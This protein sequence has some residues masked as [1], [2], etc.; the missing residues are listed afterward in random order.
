MSTLKEVIENV[1]KE[2]VPSLEEVR[3]IN[4][5]AKKMKDTIFNIFKDI[6]EEEDVFIGG[7]VSRGTYL[8]NEFDIDIFIRFPIEMDIEKV[9][10]ILFERLYSYFPPESIRK[11]YAEHP[12]AEIKVDG[13]ILNVV[14]CFK[15]QYPN[16]ISPADRSYFHKLYLQ[17]KID[18][19]R[20][21]VVLAKS[22]LKGVGVY[23]A[24]VYVGGFSG[25]LTELLVYYYDGFENF[26]RKITQ[27]YPP[28]II[29]IE[30]YYSL[31]KDI[32]QVF[33]KAPLI[34]ID[35]IDRGRNVAAAVTRRKFSMLISAAKK[36]IVNPSKIFFYPY[37]SP[38][39][40][41]KKN[42]IK[43]ISGL[44]IVAIDL[45]HKPRIED[46][47]YP[48]L[49]SFSRKLVK[50]LEVHDFKVIKYNSYSN[51][52]ERS[53]V[54][55][56]L[57]NLRLP[58]YTY[59]KGPYP[60]HRGEDD[61]LKKNTGNLTWIDFDGRWYVLKQR[62]FTNAIDLLKY[63]VE[64]PLIKIP[65]SLYDKIEIYLVDESVLDT[66]YTE[67]ELEWLNSFIVGDE[68]WKYM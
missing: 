50:Q 21:D 61:F 40:L 13:K 48:Q 64:K 9:K 36:F 67:K 47:H 55:I 28:V 58:V 15:T 66:K 10:Q 3:E 54:F 30:R 65:D 56:L 27:W 49:Q 7:S 22:F 44:N 1:K 62:S 19:L 17:D 59:S 60:Y 35:P 5:F 46:I 24:E 32:L 43:W 38:M 26:I 39:S 29:D 57:E 14:P 63:T 20:E 18:R 6:V 8:K 4:Y 37:T 2:I 51:F 11:R 52:V 16:W 12:Y 34:V 41:K 23:G 53:I 25:Y 68:F 33:G 45:F 31:K 42:L